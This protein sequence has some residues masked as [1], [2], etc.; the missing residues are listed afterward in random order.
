MKQPNELNAADGIA[1][2]VTDMTGTKYMVAESPDEGTS[3][4]KEVD[5]LL[6]PESSTAPKLAMEHTVVE[7]YEYQMTYVKR[8]YDIVSQ[9][10]AK[11]NGNLPPDRYYIL[12]VTDSLEDTLRKKKTISRFVDSVSEWV[13]DASPKLQI[14]QHQQWRYMDNEVLLMCVGSHPEINGTIGRI[15]G[16]PNQPETLAAARL[17]RSIEHGLQKFEKYKDLG[18]DTVLSLQDISGEVHPSMLTDIQTDVDKG[19]RIDQLIDYVI[20]FASINDHMIV[21]SVWKEKNVRYDPTPLNRRYE[22]K[23]GVWVPIG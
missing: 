13:M 5:F 22:N 15:P 4:V 9:V 21:G 19:P 6:A 16:S 1:Q 12:V 7:A 10:A 18:C 20:V 17:W 23:E 2:I 14:E 8:S 11:C 3:A